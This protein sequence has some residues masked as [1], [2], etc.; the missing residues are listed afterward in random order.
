MPSITI[1]EIDVTSGGGSSTNLNVVYVPGFM[2]TDS[3]AWPKDNNPAKKKTPTLC[4]SVAEFE[5]FFGTRPATWPDGSNTV[6]DKSYLYAKELLNLGLPVL[7]ESIND[8]TDTS[9]PSESA[10]YLAMAGDLFTS[11]TNKDG[12]DE[13]S[14]YS[15]K[16]LTSGGYPTFYYSPA[17][18]S[19]S[20][21]YTESPIKGEAVQLNLQDVQIGGKNVTYRITFN[22]NVWTLTKEGDSTFTPKECTGAINN[23]VSPG[24][25]EIS[26][27]GK[28]IYKLYAT[29][30][31][32]TDGEYVT[33]DFNDGGF[34]TS[35]KFY[36]V[37]GTT[38]T[39]IATKMLKLA[40]DR[41]DCIALIDHPNMPSATLVGTNSYYNKFKTFGEAATNGDY[42]AAFTPWVNINCIT[43]TPKVVAG[44]KERNNS[45]FS[46]P[47]SFGYLA[48]LAKSIKT[49]AS[50]LAVA[51]ASRG[52]I[53]NLDADK[54]L[55]IN[56]KI[57]NSIAESE[58]QNRDSVS[59][60]AITNIKP[61]GHRIWGNRTLKH[62]GATGENNLTATSFLN[63][64]NMICDVK[65]VVY[66]ACKK[67]TFEQ[68]NDVLWLNFKSAIEPTLNQMKTGAGLNGYKIIKG[69]TSEKAKLV[70]VI[71]L[72][73]LYAVEDFEISVEMRDDEV[74]VK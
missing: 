33:I 60:N 35:N 72:Y 61:F 23:T 42:G 7:Y 3:T 69:Q 17:A 22:N 1:T 63:I 4:K 56:G 21:T 29:G 43:Y 28:V 11:R 59:I 52:Q 24:Q 40:E 15:F 16:Y 57:T 67:F 47:P 44:E 38:D 68:N 53:P 5:R 27:N 71:K 48:A 58:Y 41:G 66:D 2:T 13:K 64:R 30:H 34:P 19:P 6:F 36:E 25:Y 65:K 31:K 26:Y 39:S 45:I 20:V 46:M 74:S 73:P 62:N 18:T 50:W 49:N 12:L 70:A 37:V 32:F 51:G 9:T 55:N 10:M 14:E 54:P 8:K